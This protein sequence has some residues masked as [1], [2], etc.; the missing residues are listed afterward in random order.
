[1]KLWWEGD[2]NLVGGGSLGEAF[3]GGG[4]GK[5]LADEEGSPPNPPSR[6]NSVV[7][8]KCEKF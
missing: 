3:P 2:K 7:P 6:E 8:Q 4:M 5:F 1:M